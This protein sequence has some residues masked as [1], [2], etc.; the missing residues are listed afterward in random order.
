[1]PGSWIYA[2]AV[3][4]VALSLLGALALNNARQELAS[5][6]RQVT[7]TGE[8]VCLPHKKTGF[9][10][11]GGTDECRYGFRGDDGRHY[12]LNFLDSESVGILA[13]AAESGQP[14]TISGAI[15]IPPPYEGLDRYD[16]VGA[17]DIESVST[18]PDSI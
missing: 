1:M 11:G 9:F 8:V 2:N 13:E 5:G 17:I 6:E 15:R 12:G 4:A 14:L 16:I 10:G 3:I 18:S 7:V